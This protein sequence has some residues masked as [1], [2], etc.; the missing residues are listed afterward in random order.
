[1]ERGINSIHEA[2]ET[3]KNKVQNLK[4]DIVDNT[5]HTKRNND[6]MRYKRP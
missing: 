6:R 2:N 5:A 4:D 3:Q 1:M